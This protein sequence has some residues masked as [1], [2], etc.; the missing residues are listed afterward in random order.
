MRRRT[1]VAVLGAAAAW[2]VA[3]IA[4]RPRQHVVMLEASSSSKQ[5]YRET[6]IQALEQRGWKVG[7]SVVLTYEPVLSEPDRLREGVLKVLALNPDLILT[8]SSAALSELLRTTQSVPIVFA[9]ITDPIGQGLVADL[10][11]PPG[12]VTGFVDFFPEISGKWLHLLKDVAPRMTHAAFVY[13]PDTAPYS[14]S[15]IPS[16]EAAARTH[17]VTP[18]VTQVRTVFELERAVVRMGPN[19]GLIAQSDP[20]LSQYRQQIVDLANAH[21]VP[22]VYYNSA[23]V[24]VGGLMSYGPEPTA[25]YKDAANYVDR[26]LKGTLVTDLPV[27]QPTKYDLVINLKT[28]K[29][30]GLSIAPEV[31]AAADILIE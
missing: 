26:I 16:F 15:F 6:F 29:Q 2:P 21:R 24:R 1:F 27:Q 19:A 28:A 9:R 5:L 18:V 4:Q 3:A 7:Q 23:F 31:M 17:A 14:S 11:R 20:F 8:D 10:A 25:L 13:N 30:L 22:V 12:N